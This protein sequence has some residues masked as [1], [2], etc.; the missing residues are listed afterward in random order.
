MAALTRILSEAGVGVRVHAI[1]DGR[2][3][4][5]R[6]ALDFMAHFE[7]A[8]AGLADVTI[9]SV[10]GRYYS[11]DRDSRWERT[12]LAYESYVQGKGRRADTAR[13]AIEAAYNADESDEFV[14]PT[15]VGEVPVMANG[16]GLLMANFRA[17]RVRQTLAALL[18]PAFDGFTRAAVVDFAAAV[19]MTEYSQKLNSMVA[20]LFP[21]TNLPGLLGEVVSAAG[22]RQLRIAETEKY[23]HVTYFF[24]GG[25]EQVFEGEERILVPSPKVATYDLEPEMSAEEVT[26]KVIEAIGTGR[27][28]LIVLNYANPDM[29]GHT[30]VFDA[31]VKAVETVDRCLGRARKAI[32][33]AG[34]AMLV[35]A[36]HGNVERMRDHGSAQPH[37]AHTSNRVPVVLAGMS[38]GIELHDGRLSDIAPTILG[39]LGLSQPPE[40]TGST[41]IADGSATEDNA[42]QARTALV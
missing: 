8:I 21:P 31:A 12:A 7:S 20:A 3:T 36:D 9:A 13:N 5:P 34:G 16:D 24:N 22:L 17:D 4:P 37:T 42:G 15:L 11:M 14:R 39:L 33:Q 18:D 41:L 10:A 2:D 23:A 29:V 6:S 28:D 32:E 19:G 40:M 1:L 30:G 26:D 35:T 27:F 25:K 38:D